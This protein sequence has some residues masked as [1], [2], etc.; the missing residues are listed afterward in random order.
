MKNKIN[1][2]FKIFLLILALSKFTN[3]SCDM[4]IISPENGSTVAGASLLFTGTSTQKNKIISLSLNGTTISRQST[5]G[6][7]DWSFIYP[8]TL[9]NGFYV[10]LTEILNDDF[11]ILD[12]ATNNFTVLN[13]P[14]VTILGPSEYDIIDPCSYKACGTAS[15][16]PS[17]LA[18]SIDNKFTETTIV[19][20]SGNWTAGL[21]SMQNGYHELKAE[22]LNPSRS[23]I[24]TSTQVFESGSEVFFP[25]QISQLNILI[26][27]IDTSVS[28]GEGPGFT[29]TISDP[30]I[31]ID[32]TQT[33]Y[34]TPVIIATGQKAAGDS[35]ITIV[36]A[37]NTQ[38]V[39][40]FS[41]GTE[42]V[43]F[44]AK[45]YW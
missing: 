20:L 31:T 29:Y 1:T 37:S 30:N 32:F 5:D 27:R 22:L 9:S 19:D 25:N 17:N 28:T 36:S 3:A 35:I 33:F 23:I 26:G 16:F 41:A 11:S 24:A 4:Y 12:A 6:N 15:E 39:L 45:E 8:S 18:I 44:E 43:N 13:P 21:P 40:S 34:T 7:G 2:I 42:F 38:A 14:S 10:N